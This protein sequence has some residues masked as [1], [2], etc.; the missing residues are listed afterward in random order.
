[1]R[2]Q[3]DSVPNFKWECNRIGCCH[4]TLGKDYEVSRKQRCNKFVGVCLGKLQ[5]KT[6]KRI[7]LERLRQVILS[8]SLNNFVNHRREI[9]RTY[10][11]GIHIN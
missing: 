8:I 1:M 4:I 5:N 7:S 6:N 11:Y 9:M 3:L 2:I 10:F